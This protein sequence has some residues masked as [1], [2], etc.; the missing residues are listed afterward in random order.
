MVTH[1]CRDE[2]LVE[3]IPGLSSPA[4]SCLQ[5]APQ[6]ST[7]LSAALT[8]RYRNLVHNTGLPVHAHDDLTA[9][10]DLRLRPLPYLELNTVWEGASAHRSLQDSSLRL[11]FEPATPAWTVHSSLA[12]LWFPAFTPIVA[13]GAGTEGLR[14]MG[15]GARLGSGGVAVT[16]AGGWKNLEIPLSI[17]VPNYRPLSLPLM[18]R[19][20]FQVISFEGRAKG[21]ELYTI[22]RFHQGRHPASFDSRYSLS[23]S[24][25]S[26]EHSVGAAWTGT[27]EAGR[28]RLSAEGAR[29][30]GTRTFRGT[31][32]GDDGLYQFAYEETRQRN[33]WARA[34]AQTS[35]AG[36][37]AG[38]FAAVGAVRWDALRPEIASG[39]YFWDRNGVIDSY[40]GGLLD[41]FSQETYLFDGRAGL[42]QKALGAWVLLPAGVWQC[43]LGL[44]YHRVEMEAYG[45]L[46]KKT[47]TFLITYT[48]QEYAFNFYGVEAD[49]LTPEDLVRR[50][51]GRAFIEA[52]VEQALPLSVRMRHAPGSEPGGS[53]GQSKPSKTSGGTLAWIRLGWGFL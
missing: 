53:P 47:T 33:V 48:E 37:E 35:R 10:L 1:P 38:V 45:R 9:D 19:Q 16:M 29:Y 3:A 34:D 49:L 42:S 6:D 40:E 20:T 4:G 25:R 15:F 43:R 23:D 14:E 31:R 22:S 24:G 36:R 17:D 11:A 50:Q 44:S 8:T 2:R 46:T 52:S 13:A 5:S 51:F 26:A 7:P 39:H 41:V 21:F 28:H 27:G 18:L 32:A 30:D 12:L